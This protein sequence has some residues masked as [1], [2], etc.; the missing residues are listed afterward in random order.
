MNTEDKLLARL[1][2]LMADQDRL[3]EVIRVKQTQLPRVD[4]STP[5]KPSA[6]PT[7]TELSHKSR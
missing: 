7:Q 4:G 6:V 5:A 3:L 1:A 2:A